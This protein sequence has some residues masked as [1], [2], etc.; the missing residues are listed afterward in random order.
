MNEKPPKMKM[1][2]ITLQNHDRYRFKKKDFFI[3]IQ[4]VEPRRHENVIYNKYYLLISRFYTMYTVHINVIF[5]F[6]TNFT[7]YRT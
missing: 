1:V 2:H 6:Y 3:N 5:S 4:N 7:Q